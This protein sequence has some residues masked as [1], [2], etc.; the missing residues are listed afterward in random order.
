[1]SMLAWLPDVLRDAGV[2]VYI[3]PGAETR[4]S[5]RSGL[6]P[7]GVVWHHTATGTNWSDGHVAALLRDGRRDLAGP[8][9]QVGI[10]R[11]GTWVL[12]A[13]G[14]ANHNGYGKWGND[15]IGLEFYN[16]GLGERWPDVQVESGVIGTAAICRHEG[17]RP[18]THVLGHKETDPRRKID[19]AGLNMSSIRRRTEGALHPTPIPQPL[20]EDPDMYSLNLVAYVADCY[21]EAGKPIGSDPR[22]RN[23]WAQTAAAA[24]D[25]RSVLNDM[26]SLLGLEVIA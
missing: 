22:G 4:T 24:S 5:R 19:P 8:L 20:P 7:Q 12:I 11:D 17:W 2:D 15:S 3:L 21:L 13:L 1:M 9:S 18:A 14:R 16:S 25:P 10:E 23:Y 26:R 6:S